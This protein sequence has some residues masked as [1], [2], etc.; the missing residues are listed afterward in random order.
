[1]FSNCNKL[2]ELNL[3]SFNTRNVQDMSYLFENCN[4]LKN[5]SLGNNFNTS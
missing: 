3:T 5:L 4:Y 1:M 2:N